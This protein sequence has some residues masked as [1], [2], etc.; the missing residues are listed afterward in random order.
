MSTLISFKF[1]HAKQNFAS[2][3]GIS[4][5]CDGIRLFEPCQPGDHVVDLLD[6]CSWVRVAL[7]KLKKGSL[8]PGGPFDSTKLEVR[9]GPGDCQL[10]N[11]EVLDPEASP[12]AHSGEAGGLVV[13]VAKS[14]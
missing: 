1:V 10:V 3:P 2:L 11:K 8:G 12:L 13:S 7:E 9:H 5:P 4:L 6:R 14:W